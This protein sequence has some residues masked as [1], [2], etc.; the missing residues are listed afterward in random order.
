MDDF[1]AEEIGHT[2]KAQEQIDMKS[3]VSASNTKMQKP[4]DRELNEPHQEESDLI[5]R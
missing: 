1:P 5:V 3:R 4:S 2:K